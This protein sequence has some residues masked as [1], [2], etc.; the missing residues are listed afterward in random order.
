[1]LRMSLYLVPD[2]GRLK[3]LIWIFLGA[4]A[5]S[6]ALELALRI[7]DPT[8]NDRFSND[9]A[10]GLL[11]YRPDL[12]FTVSAS[13]YENEV[14]T[15][16]LGFHAPPVPA[17][18]RPDTFRIVVVG[19]SFVEAQQVSTDRLFSSILQDALNARLGTHPRYEVIPFGMDGNGTFLNA[20]YYARF[21]SPLKPDLVIDLMTE[22]DPSRHASRTGG[23]AN[24]DK[25][26]TALA[27]PAVSRSR[28]TILAKNV[29]RRSKLVVRLVE[30]YR[31]IA[32][33]FEKMMRAPNQTVVDYI[34]NEQ[35][36][37]DEETLLGSL[38]DR[39]RQDGAS[40][41][42]ASW[43]SPYS[44][45]STAQL[46]HDRLASIA[47]RRRF[48]YLDLVPSIDAQRQREQ[49]QPTWSCDAHWNEQGHRW[50][51][52]GIAEYLWRHPELLTG[53]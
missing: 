15:N 8:P 19:S 16:Q 3:N 42:L 36:W 1:M 47:E 34:S 7:T 45:T 33:S 53:S 23:A 17:E 52:Q 49:A 30:R 5:A 20:L 46:V 13:C 39:V 22:Y 12:R 35:V 37:K 32:S 2:G 21:A 44:S 6:M 9:E 4:L 48:A 40:F 25:R 18:K 29:L 27:L 24:D 14:V 41:M 31:L 38:Q 10:S 51:A 28:L 43:V 26:A 50:A 11:V